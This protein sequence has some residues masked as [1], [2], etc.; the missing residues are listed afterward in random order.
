MVISILDDTGLVYI[1]HFACIISI[2]ASMLYPLSRHFIH[3]IH[4]SSL[5]W[6][7][8][9]HIIH[10]VTFWQSYFVHFS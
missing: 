10:F 7:S 3:D 1:I 5:W 2:L 9:I 6:L 4:Y 8:F